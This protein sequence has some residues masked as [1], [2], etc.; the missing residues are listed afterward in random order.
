MP[1]SIHHPW[2]TRSLAFLLCIPATLAQMKTFDNRNEGV[3]GYN[4]SKYDLLLLSIHRT[5]QP[6]AG[7]A[8]LR[9]RFAVPDGAS[10]PFLNAVELSI[11]KHYAME[12]TRLKPGPVYELER[13][14]TADVIDKL[15]ISW[16]NLAVSA[17]YTRAGASVYSPVEVGPS[18][19]PPGDTYRVHFRLGTSV[20]N[21]ETS[22]ALPSGKPA[23]V[24]VRP[25]S[26]RTDLFPDCTLWYDG[27]VEYV[28]LDFSKAPTGE[29]RVTLS[30]EPVL[31]PAAR[32]P[33]T[34]APVTATK[35]MP[36]ATLSFLLY[37]RS[38][39]R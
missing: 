12:A 31:P 10:A 24:L 2:L 14:P 34:P 26:C 19:P 20:R 39:K 25:V 22:V 29:Y 3:R 32:A 13:W 5:L 33:P 16:N 9:A 37:H 4:N 17:G 36:S 7:N 11:S 27:D 35:A 28:D 38:S 6:F 8:V 15:G 18:L 23:P 30:A 1:A 21:L